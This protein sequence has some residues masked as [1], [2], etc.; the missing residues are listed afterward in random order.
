MFQLILKTHLAFLLIPLLTLAL[1]PTNPSGLCDRFL[2]DKDKAQCMLKTTK[3][4]LDWYASSACALQQEDKN[5]MSCLDE[6]KGATFNP[7]ALELCAKSTDIS[8]E[9]RISCIKKIKNKDYSRAQ[10]KKCADSGELSNMESCLF[11]S[12]R[13]PASNAPAP[14]FQALEIKK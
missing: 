5:F 2:G 3:D 12:G 13:T 8:D 9:S 11:N 6:I 10:I 4:P 1:E 7:E 14:G